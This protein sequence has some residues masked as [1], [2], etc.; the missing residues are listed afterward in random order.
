MIAEIFPPEIW[1]SA[2][3]L[4]DQL[5]SLIAG[6][7]VP[8]ITTFL[9][10]NFGSYAIAGYIVLSSLISFFVYPFM[11]EYTHPP[12]SQDGNLKN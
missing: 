9:V 6:G 4:G 8:L 1:Y 5:T 2:S 11:K 12:I 7:P 3:S 10:F